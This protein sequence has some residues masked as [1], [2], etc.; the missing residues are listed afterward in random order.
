MTM[1]TKARLRAIG[2]VNATSRIGGG[3]FPR[4]LREQ[5]WGRRQYEHNQSTPQLTRDDNTHGRW[6]W[7]TLLSRLARSGIRSAVSMCVSTACS[8]LSWSV[9]FG[10]DLPR[11]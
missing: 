7:R 2:L 4:T 6:P 10:G 3:P 8:L 1:A 5:E 9:V 11:A